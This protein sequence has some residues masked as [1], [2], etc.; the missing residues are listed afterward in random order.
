MSAHHDRVPWYL[1]PI[2][3]ILRLVGFIIE[4][5]GRLV[6]AILGGVFILLGVLLSLTLIGAFIGVPIALFGLMLM[7]KAVIP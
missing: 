1:W 5:V 6:A 3:A 4:M 7:I 2:W